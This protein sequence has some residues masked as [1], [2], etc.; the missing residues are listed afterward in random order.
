MAREMKDSGVE[1]I[2]QIPKE[3]KL[4]KYKYFS[5]N[6]MGETILAEE[7]TTEGIPIYSATLDDTVFGYIKTLN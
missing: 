1:W 6:R 7:V 2:G 3:W 5:E 4:S